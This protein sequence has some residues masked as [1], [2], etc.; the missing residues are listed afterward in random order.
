MYEQLSARE[1]EAVGSEF[2]R[3]LAR[4]VF[5]DDMFPPEANGVREP[6][7]PLQPVPSDHLQL[8]LSGTPC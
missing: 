2:A 5:V 8:V 1:Q 3:Q 6:P 4:V 7:R